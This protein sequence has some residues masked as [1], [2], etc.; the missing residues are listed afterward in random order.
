MFNTANI[1][2]TQDEELLHAVLSYGTNWSTIAASHTPQRTTLA[3]K[4]RYSKLRLRHQNTAN[5]RESSS[6]KTPLSPSAGVVNTTNVKKDVQVDRFRGNGGAEE[7]E[8]EEEGDEEGD[9][10]VDEGD[11]EGDGDYEEEEER[12]VD[13][14]EHR[15]SISSASTTKST[16]S[17]HELFASKAAPHSRPNIATPPDMWT[18]Y[19]GAL[20]SEIQATYRTNKM[21]AEQWMD[22]RVNSTMY[23]RTNPQPYPSEG[24]FNAAQENSRVDMSSSFARHGTFHMAPTWMQL[25]VR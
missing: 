6:V 3:L 22:G 15:H 17:P 20:T 4:N 24:F 8:R 10:I 11:K 12:D 13:Q 7:E 23:G 1:Y 21:S 16:I 14:D 9:E 25:T 5:G 19:N 2:T 18:D